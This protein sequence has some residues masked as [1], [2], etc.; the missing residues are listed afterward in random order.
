MTTMTDKSPGKTNMAQRNVLRAFAFAAA[1]LSCAAA[2]AQLFRAYLDPSGVDTNPCTLPAPCRLLPA[3]LVAVANGGEIWML[4]SAN[5]NTGI[6]N[7]NKSVTI[8]AVPGAL[9]S[10]L[11]TGGNA[12][13][14]NTAGV[15]VAL[16]NLVI[17]PL[18]GG[19]GTGGILMAAGTSLALDNCLVANMPQAGIIV[20]TAANVR[21]SDTTIRDNGTY[22]LLL[23]N[24]A[25]ATVARAT[26]AGN[27]DTGIWVNGNIASTTTSADISAST[28]GGSVYGITALSSVASAVVKASVRGSRI[29]RNTSYGVL[30]QSNAAALVSVAASGNIISNN[31]TGILAL[32]AGAQVW[33]TGNTVTDNVTGLHNPNASFKST[34]D[35]AVRNN[36]TADTTGTISVVATQ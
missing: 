26:F 34:G 33:A 15:K 3:A 24:G 13:V 32:N 20:T 23:Q 8:L 6:V 17:V 31:G 11:A 4:D 10:V 30:A 28:L 25:R 19:G 22:G 29:V 36:A 1:L 21:I 7:I 18:V 5:Y 35:N 2:N 12:I 14:I 27:A 16:R 9:G